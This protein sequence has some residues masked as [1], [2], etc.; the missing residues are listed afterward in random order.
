[1]YNWSFLAIFIILFMH[2]HSTRHYAETLTE[3]T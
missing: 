2:S 1:M 3:D